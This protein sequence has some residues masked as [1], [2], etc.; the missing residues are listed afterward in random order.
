MV[1]RNEFTVEGK[2]EFPRDM[3][4]FD[5]CAPVTDEGRALAAAVSGDP[6]L[7]TQADPTSLER[8]RVRRYRVTLRADET[9][10]APTTARWESFGFKVV[11]VG[12][13]LRG[14]LSADLPGR[15]RQ[16]GEGTTA[17]DRARIAD[18][19]LAQSGGSRI[20][21]TLS[22]EANAALAELREMGTNPSAS[23]LVER[24]LTE[25]LARAKAAERDGTEE[26]RAPRFR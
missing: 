3:L 16:H 2:G 19:R 7:E 25:E 20:T 22:P 14:R 11:A 23:R 18:A 12:T 24:L 8:T 13:G 21:V 17:A 1:R 4:R 26:R 5:G 6:V 15:P 10:G 9:G